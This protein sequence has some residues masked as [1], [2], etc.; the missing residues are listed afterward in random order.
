MLAAYW[1]MLSPS[2]RSLALVSLQVSTASVLFACGGSFESKPFGDASGGTG[3]VA[4]VTGGASALGGATAK[5][6]GSGSGGSMKTG[7]LTGSGGAGS[8]KSCLVGNV[9]YADGSVFPSAD[10]CN[11]CSCAKGSVACTTRACVETICGGDAGNTCAPDEYCAYAGNGLCGAAD[12][13]STCKK[14]PQ[15]CTDIFAPVCGCDGKTYPSD[16][17]AAAAGVGFSTQGECAT[18]GS[19]TIGN[20]VYADGSANIP[21]PDGCNTCSCAGGVAACT[22]LACKSCGGI[23]GVACASN[24]YC[25]YGSVGLPLPGPN[26]TCLTLDA[27]GVCLKRPEVCALGGPV[28]PV[29]AE[30]AIAINVCGCDGQTYFNAC[31]ANSAGTDVASYGSCPV[32]TPAF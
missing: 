24:E 7:G 23:A 20:W 2:F 28:L 32:P 11:S 1:I 9:E 30:I 25:S 12:A 16:C 15:I 6:G 5:S 31:A 3:G 27:S 22:E 18:P 8:G 13:S 21:A 4:G 17:S 14:R 19:C 29:P 26:L 10:G